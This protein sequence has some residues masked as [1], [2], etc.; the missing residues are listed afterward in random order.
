MVKQE[1][2]S[3]RELARRLN[4]SEATIRKALRDGR[5]TSAHTD[6]KG[7]HWF[8]EKPARKQMDVIW[9]ARAERETMQAKILS[10]KAQKMEKELVDANEVR[11]FWEDE[12]AYV[13]KLFLALPAQFKEGI[14]TLTEKEVKMIKD[15]IVDALDILCPWEKLLNELQKR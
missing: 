1:L 10:L 8:V 12:R 7:K 14:P 6:A 13:R 2:I 3:G 11:K 9:K 5:I 15:R 4:V